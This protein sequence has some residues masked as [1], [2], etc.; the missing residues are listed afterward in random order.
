MFYRK[1]MIISRPSGILAGQHSCN[2]AVIMDVAAGK[3]TL[4]GVALTV[5]IVVI[6]GT[7][8]ET[9]PFVEKYNKRQTRQKKKRLCNLKRLNAGWKVLLST[10]LIS[11]SHVPTSPTRKQLVLKPP[12]KSELMSLSSENKPYQILLPLDSWYSARKPLA[13]IILKKCTSQFCNLCK[14]KIMFSRRE[15]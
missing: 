13:G 1:D 11:N 3:M 6:A 5:K 14:L 4:I 15:N 7:K 12:S 9:L 2:S 8:K 10:A